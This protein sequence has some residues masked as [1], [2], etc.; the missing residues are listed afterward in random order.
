MASE[1]TWP[2]LDADRCHQTLTTL[3]LATQIVGKVQLALRP[4]MAHWAQAPLRL[5]A[6]GLAT[7][8]LAAGDTTLT[9]TFDLLAHEL[10]FETSDGDQRVVGLDPCT[11]ADFYDRVMGVLDDLGVAVRIDPVTVVTLEP[12]RCDTDTAARDYDRECAT[13]YFQALTRMAPVFEQY[14]SGFWGKQTPVS[15]WWGT[16]DLAVT[17]YSSRPAR[18]PQDAGVIERVAMDAEQAIVGFW[19][20]DEQTPNPSFFATTYPKPAGLEMAEVAPADAHW[21]DEL[22]QFVLSYDAVRAQADPAAALL[23]FC[24]STYA[25]G[26][27]LGRWDR[28]L[29]ER[30]APAR[31][32]P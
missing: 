4:A 32:W 22:G 28:S 25:A 19:P 7:H 12:V 23:E 11:L 10:R 31:V 18:P 21:D 3:H 8:L 26:A 1:Q 6:R 13:A 14:R 27:R 29:L 16:F 15:L 9:L 24:E 30:S 2:A 20:G 5:T 17:R